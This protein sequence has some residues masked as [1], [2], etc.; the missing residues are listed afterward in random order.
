MIKCP[1]WNL[2]YWLIW[3][4]GI[5]IESICY[6]FIWIDFWD[7]LSNIVGKSSSSS[8]PSSVFGLKSR[9]ES[10][11]IMQWKV[12]VAPERQTS[13]NYYVVK[14]WIF[15]DSSKRRKRKFQHI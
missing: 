14:V 2:F 4:M 13:Y 10:T 12:L 9:V 8:T 3:K 7:K 15:Y 11:Y 1:F 6:S 5:H